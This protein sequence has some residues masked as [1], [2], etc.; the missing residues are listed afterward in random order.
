MARKASEKV[1]TTPKVKKGKASKNAAEISSEPVAIKVNKLTEEGLEGVFDKIIERNT[2]NKPPVKEKYR[3]PKKTKETVAEIS[4]PLTPL[5]KKAAELKKRADDKAAKLKK[6]ANKKASRL[7]KKA[8]GKAAVL[9]AKAEDKTSRANRKIDRKAVKR[10]LKETI[11]QA[12]LEAARKLGNIPLE[13]LPADLDIDSGL[14]R[15]PTFKIVATR[16]V[17]VATSLV[18]L[19]VL[20]GFAYTWYIGQNPDTTAAVTAPVVAETRTE[21]KPLARA[22][23]AKQGVAVQSISSP[24]QPG[25]EASIYIRTSPASVCTILVKYNE[26]ASKDPGLITKTADEYGMVDWTWSVGSSTPIGKWPV[27][28]TCTRNSKTAVVVGDLQVVQ[29]IN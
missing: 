11:K 8:Y 23:N 2:Q 28:V 19:C 12:K 15:K 10:E 22:E 25:S 27:T 18:V 29:T 4:R 1:P 13:K 5:D 3:P 24:I 26:I 20:A 14:R 21:V 9:Q 16:L 17:I 7:K 6:K